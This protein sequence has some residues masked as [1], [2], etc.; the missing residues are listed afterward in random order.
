MVFKDRIEEYFGKNFSQR[1]ERIFYQ[2]SVVED[3]LTVVE[4]GT[5]ENGGTAMH[6]A[7]ECGIWGGFYELA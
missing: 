7:T 2:M 6:D 1:A 5:R 3:A 4:V